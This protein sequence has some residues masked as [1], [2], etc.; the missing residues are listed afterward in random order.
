MFIGCHHLL[1]NDQNRHVY[2]K[3]DIQHIALCIL[4]IM[5]KKYRRA[6]QK[7]NNISIKSSLANKLLH[8]KF[9]FV[10]VENILKIEFGITQLSELV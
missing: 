6:V 2:R 5:V 9:V 8:F 1:K 7:M 4:V 10:I 3:H